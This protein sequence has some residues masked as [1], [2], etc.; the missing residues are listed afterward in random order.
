MAIT[1]AESSDSILLLKR[2][3]F[4]SLLTRPKVS[5]ISLHSLTVINP[6]HTIHGTVHPPDNHWFH[7]HHVPFNSTERRGA[8]DDEQPCAGT[9]TAGT[10]TAGRKPACSLPEG[11]C[12][13]AGWQT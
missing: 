6:V 3:S 1:T 8:A 4:A 2:E 11:R 7:R 10:K 5:L 12:H 13:G 9:K